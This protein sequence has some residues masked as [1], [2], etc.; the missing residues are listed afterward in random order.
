MLIGVLWLAAAYAQSADFRIKQLTSEIEGGVHQV[1]LK[2][3]I[4]FSDE[5]LEALRNGVALV[6]QVEIEVLR[7]R[8]YWWDSTLVAL[9]QRYQLRY[10]ALSQSYIVRNLNTDAQESLRTLSAALDALSTT[11][12][13]PV[14]DA[15]LVP[16]NA[17]YIGR[18]RVLLD[19][20]ALPLPLK[21]RAYTSPEWRAASDWRQWSLQ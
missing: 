15:S 17:D 13:I 10:H 4:N 9:K 12:D 21:M 16:A 7:P 3:D 11:N 6:V 20:D 1:S 19:I 14:V 8:S 18:L 5:M 2:L